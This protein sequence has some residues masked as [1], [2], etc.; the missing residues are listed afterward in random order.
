MNLPDSIRHRLSCGWP[1]L[2][3]IAFLS[4]SAGVRA[5][6]TASESFNH[7]AAGSLGGQGG[8]LFGWNGPWVPG[9]VTGLTAE[10]VDT[11]ASGAI[12]VTPAGGSAISG[13]TRALDVYPPSTGGTN[14]AARTGIAATR[15]LAAA[16]TGTFYAAFVMKWQSGTFNSNDTFA[17]H[18]TNS[19]TDTANGFNF[20]YRGLPTTYGVMVRK[21][22]AS[23]VGGAFSTFASSTNGTVRHLVAKFEKTGAANYDKITLWINPGVNSEVDLPN[24]DCQLLADS[25]IAEIT[26]VSIRVENLRSPDAGS[27]GNDKVRLDSLSLAASFADLMS[28]VSPARPFIWVRDSEKAGIL[29]KIAA[30]PWAT[31]VYNGMV[32]RVAADLASHQANRDT[33]LRAACRS[34]GRP[35]RPSSKPS[36]PTRKARCAFRPRRNINDALDCAV[37]YYLTGDAQLR[38]MRG[39][40][41]AQRHED[42]A[43][44]G[45]FHQHRQRRLDLP[46]RPPQGSAGHRHAS[47]RSSTISSTPGSRPTKSTT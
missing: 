5:E 46:D 8:T 44:R 12:S 30:Q 22:T 37:L 26:S 13:L 2:V 21:G 38:P 6:V 7:Y 3:M 31:S 34:I 14:T 35:P 47:C 23:P 17:L 39:R 9:S 27:N 32:S 4:A 29:A 10:I 15:Q 11:S 19:A 42:P 43:A 33:F 28:S 1:S 36:R 20:G 24:G 40:H 25:G 16:Q 41:P 18:F 45:R